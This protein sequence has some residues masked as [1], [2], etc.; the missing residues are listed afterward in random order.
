M[1]W[2]RSLFCEEATLLCRCLRVATTVEAATRCDFFLSQWE[3]V[4]TDDS[5][6]YLRHE[7]IRTPHPAHGRV[8]E[9]ALEEDANAMVDNNVWA[10]TDYC[11]D[12]IDKSASDTLSIEWSFSIVYSDTYQVP[13]LY[14]HVQHQDGSPC[15]R[16]QVVQWL[17]ASKLITVPHPFDEPETT[18][19]DFV[20]QE[21]HPHTGFPSYFLH[22]CRT[23]ERMKLLHQSPGRDE[24][25][26]INFLWVWMSMVL[27]AVNHPIPSKVF[28]NLQ[29]QMRKE[30]NNNA[31]ILP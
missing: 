2:S 31:T 20:S 7:P 8:Y 24:S 23:S 3:L 4:E 12:Y 25:A 29:E 22:P 11:T 13:T 21:H 17:L 14:F 1:I 18:S 28:W 6:A 26:G 10:D 15:I 5:S 30:K 16:S 19:W 27:P 9:D